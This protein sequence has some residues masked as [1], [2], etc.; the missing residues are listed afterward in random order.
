[1]QP[2]KLEQLKQPMLTCYQF[3]GMN[4]Y[5][6]GVS[7]NEWFT[8]L[9]DHLTK[10]TPLTRNWRLPEWAKHP[11]ILKNL[12]PYE[13]LKTYQLYHDCGKPACRVVDAEGKQHFPNHAQESYDTWLQACDETRDD[14]V[15]A[16]LIRDDMLAH[17]VKGEAIDQFV[18]QDTA[19]SLLLTA[20]AEI[21]SNANHLGQLESDNFKIKAKQLDKVGKRL[22]KYLE[23][24]NEKQGTDKTDSRT[25]P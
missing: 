14:L 6:H 12:L 1:M 22:I 9:Y 13:I 20:L 11:L 16:S 18:R 25:R 19:S 8:D 15:V 24:Q 10:G 5:E 21:H 23:E 7:V 4:V 17:T 2:E 3:S